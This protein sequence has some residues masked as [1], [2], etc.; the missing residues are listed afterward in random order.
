MRVGKDPGNRWFCLKDSHHAGQLVGC[1]EVVLVTEGDD[2]APAS[3]HGL[4][5]VPGRSQVDGIAKKSHWKGSC[6]SK[7]FDIVG[8]VVGGTIVEDDELGG[9]QGLSTNRVQLRQKMAVSI[10]G[11]QR[12][13]YLHQA[14]FPTIE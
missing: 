6:L 14:R 11:T 13:R 12:N 9:K 8:R 1:P 10:V 7:L 4:L 3:L 5:E 2:L